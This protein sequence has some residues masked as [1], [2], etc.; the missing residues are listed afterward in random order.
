MFY[1]I[2]WLTTVVLCATL[3]VA[4]TNSS[5]SQVETP[6]LDDIP[7][8]VPTPIP[9]AVPPTPSPTVEVISAEIIEAA[10]SAAT[11]DAVDTIIIGSR[12]TTEQEILG[13]LMTQLLRANG[14]DVADRSGYGSTQLVREALETGEINLYAEY[15]GTALSLHHGIPLEALPNDPVRTYELAK[16]MDSTSGFAWLKMAD[17]SSSYTMLVRDAVAT[18][19]IE[20]LDDLSELLAT[21][22]A[23]LKVCV[24]SDF[25]ALRETGLRAMMA[26]Y[27]LE[28]P[29]ENII[30]TSAD[31]A[32][33]DLRS[34]ACDVA[35]GNSTDARIGAWGF[36][37]L[38][39]SQQFFPS[40]N[41]SPVL[42]AE[43]LERHPELVD[44]LNSLF[45]SISA[46]TIRNLNMQVDLGPDG[47]F[48]TGDERAAAEVAQNYLLGAGLLGDAPQLTL[49]TINT[50]ESDIL[51]GI[52]QQVLEA[53]GFKVEIARFDDS[54]DAR[55]ALL[56][57]NVDLV[58]ESTTRVLSEF[59]NLPLSAVPHNGFLSYEIAR[60]L[61]ERYAALTWLKPLNL[62]DRLTAVMRR[63]AAAGP[64]TYLDDIYSEFE[65]GN[66]AELRLCAEPDVA[67]SF[68]DSGQ[69]SYGLQTDNVEVVIADAETLYTNLNEGL[70]DVLL[71][72]SLDPRI[73]ANGLRRVPDPSE[74]FPATANAP[75]VRTILTEQF[76]DIGTLLEDAMSLLDTDE[77][78]T[79]MSRV[80]YGPDGEMGSG[81]EFGLNAVVANFLEESSQFRAL[82][83]ITIGAQP[84]AVHLALAEV[85]A[86]VLREAGF[87]VIERYNLRN[88]EVAYSELT[89]D[90]IDVYWAY[91][92]DTLEQIHIVDQAPAD[93]AAAYELAK[94]RDEE[95]GLLWLDSAEFDNAYTVLATRDSLPSDVVTLTDLA[96]FFSQNS[97]LTVCV[98]GDPAS[99]ES[100][101][102]SMAEHYQF[103]LAPDQLVFS[104]GMDPVVD[105]LDGACDVTIGA[106]SSGH[107]EAAGV[108]ALGDDLGYFSARPAAPIVTTSLAEHY[109]EAVGLLNAISAE[110]D[111]EAVRQMV[112]RT[113]IGPDGVVGSRD[114]ESISTVVNTFNC[115]TGLTEIG[116]SL[117]N[118]FGMSGFQG[119]LQQIVNS[120]DSVDLNGSFEEDRVW[121]IPITRSS[122]RYSTAQAHSGEQSMQIGAQ[123][124]GRLE[125][126]SIA[127]TTLTIP[128]DVVSAD[129][130]FWYYPISLDQLGGDSASLYVFDETLSIAR[131]IIPFPIEQGE[132]WSQVTFDLSGYR[133]DT[134]ILHILVVNDG[135]GIP[136]TV[137][138]DD[139]QFQL[140]SDQ[141][142]Q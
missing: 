91:A 11:Q 12:E 141:E 76:P 82:P 95:L 62:D 29:E 57:G 32:Y 90:L 118:S 103:S 142:A 92:G 33:E 93:A 22:D 3:V 44:L 14:Y 121:R 53:E 138:V 86:D 68:A 19:G 16:T 38:V 48:D 47:E 77:M 99:N 39:D 87:N 104:E 129:L 24:D 21:T 75:I 74:R 125:S 73:P 72:Q 117:S 4:C 49:G 64:F 70:C 97:E 105:M 112:Y 9:T 26:E 135:D 130:S 115:E 111:V 88:T 94:L 50:L 43:L 54:Q 67:A 61:D 131:D 30:I 69:A 81:D 36:T 15:N 106:R 34:G 31:G 137:Y 5:P 134:V 89:S 98:N 79:L 136:S 51:I 6:L 66:S 109:P 83:T 42:N 71:G 55:D 119:A 18:Q 110:I 120:C 8:V 108:R 132:A 96:Q 128:N 80:A 139:L 122:A 100:V 127:Q 35:Q 107:I 56:D 58:W 28:I 102:T 41:P 60:S 63:D 46:P 20:T 84:N 59:H 13:E 140:C 37:S 114:E 7:T 123:E 124:G 126:H 23:D 45:K 2:W 116:C 65:T 85:S 17:Y 133:G 25:F 52:T 101:A 113:E 27:N 10:V 78:A 40:Y 1:R